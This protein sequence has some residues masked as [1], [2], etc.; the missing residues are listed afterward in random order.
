MCG[1]KAS[2]EPNVGRSPLRFAS[3]TIRERFRRERRMHDHQGGVGR[4]RDGREILTESRR[5]ARARRD[6]RWFAA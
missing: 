4:R 6:R 5:F 2:R 1:E 3:V